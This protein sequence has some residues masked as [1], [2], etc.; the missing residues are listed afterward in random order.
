MGD[1]CATRVV[2]LAVTSGM[3][4][5]SFPSAAP[6]RWHSCPRFDA[7]RGARRDPNWGNPG[8]RVPDNGIFDAETCSGQ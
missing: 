4:D 5:T 1:V 8:E 6:A 2:G 7:G 3:A